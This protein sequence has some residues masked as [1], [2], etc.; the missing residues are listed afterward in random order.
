MI[1]TWN[2]F[3]IDRNEYMLR[4]DTANAT[5]RVLTKDSATVDGANNQIVIPNAT[6]FG[7]TAE[8]VGLSGGTAFRQIIKGVIKTVANTTSLVGSNIATDKWADAGA[9]TWSVTATADNTNKCLAITVTG[10]AATN[11][12]WLAI[13]TS[14]EIS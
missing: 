2:T 12:R 7:F 6:G 13:V 3:N 8:I 9:S 4:G 11:I 14:L 10:Q 1:T 5:P